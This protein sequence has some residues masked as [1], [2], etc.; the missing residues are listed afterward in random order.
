MLKP[1]GGLSQDQ[2][3]IVKTEH[4]YWKMDDLVKAMLKHNGVIGDI[5]NITHE[6]YTNEMGEILDVT[7]EIWEDV[8]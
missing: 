8:I 7:F 2:K 1:F 3:K 5:R 6:V 4:L